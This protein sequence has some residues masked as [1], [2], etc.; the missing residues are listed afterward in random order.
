MS[1][2]ALINA[3][4]YYI[5]TCVISFYLGHRIFY[6]TKHYWIIFSM[7]HCIQFVGL[8]NIHTHTVS[9][10]YYSSLLTNFVG[11]VDLYVRHISIRLLSYTHTHTDIHYLQY[12]F[13]IHKS[14]PNK[15]GTQ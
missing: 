13:S 9:Y 12:N 15:I 8:H 4:T 5:S 1:F 10:N 14:K 7:G 11:L 6:T 3:S 2:I